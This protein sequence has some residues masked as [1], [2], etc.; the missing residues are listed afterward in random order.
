MIDLGDGEAKD[1]SLRQ[2][3]Q[4]NAFQLSELPKAAIF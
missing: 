2:L 4:E 1:R 3:L